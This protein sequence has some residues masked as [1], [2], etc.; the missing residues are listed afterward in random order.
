MA[1]VGRDELHLFPELPGA[2]QLVAC[3][4]A[5]SERDQ[6]VADVHH[7]GRGRRQPL[8]PGQKTAP[9]RIL[10]EEH[11]VDA[12]GQRRMAVARLRGHD[13]ARG[14]PLLL[15][16]IVE[17]ADAVAGRADVHDR[18]FRIEPI[19]DG[20]RVADQRRRI[21]V[22]SAG[23]AKEGD[24]GL[25][26]GREESADLCRRGSVMDSR[27]GA[28]G[29]LAGV[30]GQPEGRQHHTANR[31]GKGAEIHGSSWISG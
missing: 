19:E 15:R 16:Q 23:I 24:D 27:R 28:G 17:R 29:R 6:P 8:R 14:E 22:L 2:E 12:A 25:V 21:L 31:P 13:T 3:H 11:V 10:D 4:F 18:P 26:S 1:H 20:G 30:R 9:P 5:T 7:R